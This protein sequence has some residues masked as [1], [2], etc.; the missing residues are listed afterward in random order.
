MSGS[1]DKG[2]WVGWQTKYEKGEEI[3]K[4]NNMGLI[5]QTPS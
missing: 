2:M 1:L 3:Q 5:P 4:L